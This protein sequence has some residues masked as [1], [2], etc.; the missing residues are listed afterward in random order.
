MRMHQEA[1]QDQVDRTD[2]M[3]KF[4]FSLHVSIV[5]YG[6]NRTVVT[7]DQ[8]QPSPKILI[9]EQPTKHNMRKNTSGSS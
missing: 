3:I 2:A 1:F 7:A 5:L 9:S 6:I 8:E 4:D